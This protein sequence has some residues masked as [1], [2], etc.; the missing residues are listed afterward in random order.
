MG[1]VHNGVV[2]SAVVLKWLLPELLTKCN[3]GVVDLKTCG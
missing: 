1:V 2:K 3:V